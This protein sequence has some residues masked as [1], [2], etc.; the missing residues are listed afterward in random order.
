VAPQSSPS[1]CAAESH[2]IMDRTVVHLLR[3]GEVFNPEKVL[4]GRLPGYH[5]SDL[6][7]QMADRAAGALAGRDLV[8]VISSPM[9]RAQETAAPIAESHGLPIEIQPKVS[10]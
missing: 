9:E 2:L 4:Y 6:G 8:S 5:L 10:A 7:R 1:G 3:H